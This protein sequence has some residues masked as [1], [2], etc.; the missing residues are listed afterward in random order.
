MVKILES[1]N[2]L[3][4]REGLLTEAPETEEEIRKSVK[5]FANNPDDTRLDNHSLARKMKGK[6]AFSVADDIRIVYR[7]IGKSTVRFLAIGPHQ[8]VYT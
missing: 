3:K 5:W 2:Y 1:G 6:W 7:W 4:M 8:E